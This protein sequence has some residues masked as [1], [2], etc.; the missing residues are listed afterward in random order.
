MGRSEWHVDSALL[1]LRRS[2]LYSMTGT[3]TWTDA[4]VHGTGPAVA[5]HTP[6]PQTGR[7]GDSRAL[8]ATGRSNTFI[9][10]MASLW[11]TL[12]G[13]DLLFGK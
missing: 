13:V 12:T 3:E 6:L 9:L 4:H 10:W 8:G 1:R 7:R 2:L 11:F 5:G